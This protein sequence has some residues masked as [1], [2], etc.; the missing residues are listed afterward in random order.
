VDLLSSQRTAA[1]FC[2]YVLPLL[3]WMAFIFGM[4]T[5]IGSSESTAGLFDAV[6]GWLLPALAPSGRHLVYFLWRKSGHVTEY[7]ILAVLALR[8]VRQDQP[9]WEWRAAGTAVLLCILYAASDEWHQSFVPSRTSDWH[10][11][12]IDTGGILL[13]IGIAWLWHKK[14][15]STKR[16]ARSRGARPGG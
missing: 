12:L 6:A 2:R 4:S 13:G 3:A 9:A 5:R 14:A 1:R 11:V 10:D 16:E 8:A 7:A 15:R